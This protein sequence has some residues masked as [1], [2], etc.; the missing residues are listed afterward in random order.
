MTAAVLLERMTR[1]TLELTLIGIVAG[2]A[3]GLIV[4]FVGGLHRG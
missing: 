1:T 3:I 4:I 2:L